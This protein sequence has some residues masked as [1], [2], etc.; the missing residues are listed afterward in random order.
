M[1]Q[2]KSIEQIV[3]EANAK[4]NALQNE[5]FIANAL[6]VTKYIFN[7]YYTQRARQAKIDSLYNDIIAGIEEVEDATGMLIT[8]TKES[9]YLNTKGDA[10][11]IDWLNDDSCYEL[12][13]NTIA[14]QDY[15]V[16]IR[17][18]GISEDDDLV[19]IVRL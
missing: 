14:L 18:V 13:L 10:I 4:F 11:T 2:V 3:S 17:E 12:F 5:A 7:A 15:K 19:I 6:T 8:V 1:Q 16:E 9:L